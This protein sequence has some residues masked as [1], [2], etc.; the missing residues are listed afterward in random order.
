MRY[1][2]WPLAGM[3]LPPPLDPVPLPC[4]AQNSEPWL[5]EWPNG[6]GV[7]LEALAGGRTRASSRGS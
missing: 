3:G 1:F 2:V 4:P 7:L 5:A 6:E